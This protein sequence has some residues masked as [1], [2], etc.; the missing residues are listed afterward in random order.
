MV[1]WLFAPQNDK[2]C[3]WYCDNCN[4]LLNAQAGFT[5]EDAE[6]ECSNCGHEIYTDEDDC[7]GIIEVVW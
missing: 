2:G 6:W 3:W 7:D 1:K 4:A 5:T